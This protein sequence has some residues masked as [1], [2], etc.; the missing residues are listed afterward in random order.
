MSMLIF[1]AWLQLLNCCVHELWSLHI[2]LTHS[3]KY[4]NQYQLWYQNQQHWVY[5]ICVILEILTM[6]YGIFLLDI[7]WYIFI[8]YLKIW[9]DICVIYRLIFNPWFNVYWSKELTICSHA[10]CRSN[11]KP[12][13][14]IDFSDHLS[15]SVYEQNP[16]FPNEYAKLIMSV[17]FAPY[18]SDYFFQLCSRCCFFAALWNTKTCWSSN[19]SKT[20]WSQSFHT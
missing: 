18:L 3:L 9:Y 16:C 1:R 4:Q 10:V 2:C 12:Y 7:V 13:L 14:L 17:H 6:L 19:Y 20:C 11:K 15:I 8:G 5:H